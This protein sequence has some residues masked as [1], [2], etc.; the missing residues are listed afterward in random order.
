MLK[1][2]TRIVNIARALALVLGTACASSAWAAAPSFAATP[3]MPLGSNVYGV[4][5]ADFNGDGLADV[6][7]A[8]G[9]VWLNTS[10]GGV[11][12]FSESYLG[13]VPMQVASADV[14]GDGKPDLIEVLGSSQVEVLLNTT[15]LGDSAIS[16][17]APVYFNTGDGVVTVATADFNGDGMPDLVLT[18]SGDIMVDVLLNTTTPGDSNVT[19]SNFASFAAG[20]SVR[21]IATGDFNGDGLP[22]IAALDDMDATVSVLIN[23]TGNGGTVPSFAAQ[24]VFAVGSWPNMITTA[25]INGDGK[26]DIVVA[27]NGENALSVLLDTTAHGS[28]TASFGAEQ[29]L[30][31]GSTPDSVVAL[32]VDGDGKIDLVSANA[33]DGTVSVLMNNTNPGD[34][35]ISFDS[36]V[37]FTVGDDPENLVAAD[38]DGDGRLDLVVLNTGASSGWSSASL[39]LNTTPVV[40]GSAGS[41]GATLLGSCKANGR[42]VSHRGT[43]RRPGLPQSNCTIK[44]KNPRTSVKGASST[45]VLAKGSKG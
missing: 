9:A 5:T 12:S 30:E 36:Q 44:S 7:T 32:D 45:P 8:D 40:A 25:D 10:S 31:T 16:F 34:T 15:Q 22:D 29:T 4:T 18:S 2:D 38:V 24:Q 14:N 35:T 21:W 6:V 33:G 23:T 28:A 19:F 27:N 11:T 1:Q 39:L 3:D 41:S 26:A 42:P 43:A 37:V 17:A 13:D 20:S